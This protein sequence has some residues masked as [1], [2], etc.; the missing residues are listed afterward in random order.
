MKLTFFSSVLGYHQEGLSNAF[1]DL[2]GENFRFVTFNELPDYRKAAGFKDLADV[3]PYVVKAYSE[4]G[5]AIVNDLLKTS[6][7]AIVGAAGNEI[8]KKCVESGIETYLFSERFFK[9]GAWRAFVLPIRKKVKRRAA[10]YKQSNFKVLCA[11]A[12]LSY[13]LSLCGWKGNAYKWGYFPEVKKYNIDNLLAEKSGTNGTVELLW[14]ARLIELKHPEKVLELAKHLKNNNIQF[15]ITM[16]GYGELE[17]F[18]INQIHN[19]ELS[20]CV[21]YIGK[22]TVDEVRQHME[23]ADIFLMTSDYHEG[24]G[25]T[26]NESLNSACAVVADSAAGAVEYMIIDGENGF[27]YRDDIRKIFPIMEKLIK[28][29]EFR[30]NI[31]RNAY[32]YMINNATPELVAKRFIDMC[33]RKKMFEDG[34]CSPAP[35]IKSKWF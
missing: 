20:G 7:V 33:E 22:K 29:R 19:A 11:S 34:F 26:I 15:H 5:K 2:L 16:I 13:D 17:D 32:E 30:Q 28:N 6:D 8:I 4:E 25:V 18:V 12:Y 31:Q 23:K 14:A 35:I 24:W 27:T 3:Y 9:K 10:G 1:Y 21:E